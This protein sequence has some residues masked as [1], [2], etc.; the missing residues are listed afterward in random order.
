MKARTLID[1]LTLSSNMYL[2][3][4]DDDFW[5]QLNAITEE[6]KN[7]FNKVIEELIDEEGEEAYSMLKKIISK[8][9]EAR[10]ELEKKME[11]ISVKAYKKMH[12]VHTDEIKKLDMEIEQ[13]KKQLGLAEARI[14][15]IEQSRRNFFEK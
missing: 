7:T 10:E 5:K 1:L 9:K 3:A 14:V 8:A 4:K 11:E 6:G 2:I 12:I 13:L 15:A